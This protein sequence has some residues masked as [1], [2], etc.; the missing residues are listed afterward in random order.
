MRNEVA[1]QYYEILTTKIKTH[2][3]KTKI[4][5]GKG[6]RKTKKPTRRKNKS[7]WRERKRASGNNSDRSNK[8]DEWDFLFLF[9]DN[10]F[11]C[12]SCC[13]CISQAVITSLD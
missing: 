2:R 9:E 5:P 1:G 4:S 7:D 6:G 8:R 11:C 12:S 3:A 10:S 13:C